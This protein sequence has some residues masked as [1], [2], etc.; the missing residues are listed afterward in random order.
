MRIA[1]SVSLILSLVLCTGSITN[2]AYKPLRAEGAIPEIFLNDLNNYVKL[3]EEIYEDYF[4]DDDKLDKLKEK[5]FLGSALNSYFYFRSGMILFGDPITR[6][7]NKVK[8][9]VF[10]N[11]PEL[12]GNIN[13]FTLKSSE[14][15]AYCSLDGSVYVTLGL[16]ARLN[17]EAELAFI[18]SHEAAHYIAKHSM[19]KLKDV[20]EIEKL[21]KERKKLTLD[22]V[23]GVRLKRSK[24]H[25]FE[26]D[27]IGLELFKA[28][29]YYRKGAVNALTCLSYA[30]KSVGNEPF[31]KKA[32]NSEYFVIPDCFFQDNVKEVTAN[33]NRQD[34][35][36][37]H[38]DIHHRKERINARLRSLS[39][40][41]KYFLVGKQEFE[42]VKELAI[43]E[44]ISR[45]LSN[46]NYAEA[47]FT[48][49]NLLNKYPGNKFLHIAAAKAL[50]YSAIYKNNQLFHYAGSP[51]SVI[52]GESQQVHYFLKQLSAVQLNTL[53]LKVVREKKMIYPGES[54][55]AKM[56]KELIDALV[57]KHGV[58][59]NAYMSVND[60]RKAYNEKYGLPINDTVS[61]KVKL[62][63]EY[64]NFYLSALYPM[65]DDPDVQ[66]LFKKAEEKKLKKQEYDNLPYKEKI[67]LEKIEEKSRIANGLDINAKNVVLI[68]PE[69]FKYEKDKVSTILNSDSEKKN[70]LSGLE[71]LISSRRENILLLQT[72]NLKSGDIGRYNDYCTVSEWIQDRDNHLS[73]I[74]VL[75]A[76]NQSFRISDKL[77]SY[78]HI[79][80]I[81]V[82]NIP[83][84]FQYY[85]FNL[86]KVEDGQC[87]YSSQKR[88]WAGTEV[89]QVLSFIQSDLEKITK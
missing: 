31:D 76:D 32:F 64:K 82:V 71:K 30:H 5:L 62:R 53:A 46:R 52:E 85:R 19:E 14:V 57:I 88:I 22:D 78:E 35:Y 68:E 15:N 8:G 2:D 74:S 63:H 17:S 61:G 39:D 25:E 73:K 27:S 38:P 9:E 67:K 41:G 43:F 55:L 4:Q 26:A 49:G 18:L 47:I 24:E 81:E 66:N 79:C 3:Q 80:K 77:A 37:T 7:L 86:F 12:I 42:E 56:E 70:F 6:Y 75:P 20:S 13:V 10:R 65:K 33:E 45:L 21:S 60:A 58:S 51:Y 54:D 50:Y 87:V 72:S 40:E 44:L 48:S 84:Y 29:S 16:L 59:L 36:S 89:S 28:S 11:N 69:Y 1:L 34:R 83:G 23:L